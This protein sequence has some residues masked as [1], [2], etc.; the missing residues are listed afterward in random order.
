[1]KFLKYFFIATVFFLVGYLSD[2][3]LTIQPNS[4]T[5]HLHDT[6]LLYQKGNNIGELYSGAILKYEDS[7]NEG[8]KRVSLIMNYYEQN[9]TTKYYHYEQSESKNLT[10]PCW[11]NK[12]VQPI[13]ENN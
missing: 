9:D 11:N 2:G 13:A 6:I 10:I 4:T 12:D 8:F 7:F 5:Y 3:F 1:M